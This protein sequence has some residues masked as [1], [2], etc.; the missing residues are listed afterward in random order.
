MAVVATPVQAG[1]EWATGPSIYDEEGQRS[2]GATLTPYLWL[3]S[4]DGTVGLPSV[5][6]IPVSSSFDA[7][8]ANLDSGIAGVLDLRF[9]R[10]HLF[11][12]N[13]WVRLKS[14]TVP[15]Q[16]IF[17]SATFISSSAFG[18]VGLAYELPLDQGF[19]VDV[20]LGA[21]W[22]RI[23]NEAEIDTVLPGA[24]LRGS[25]QDTWASAIVG[26]RIRY[27]ITDHWRVSAVADVGGGNSSLDWSVLGAVGYDFADWIGA[28]AGYRVLG[29]DYSKEGFVYDVK[30]SG[31]LLGLTLR[32]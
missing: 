2:W 1:W 19:A 22:W 3:S 7:L 17:K 27:R 31:L 12:D 13:S 23:A 20:Y 26:T 5:G 14:V 25:L 16:S 29:V 6:T 11:S 32:Y 18:T 9:R 4:L 21:R 30:Q 28:T 24:T 8:A 10:W 15:E